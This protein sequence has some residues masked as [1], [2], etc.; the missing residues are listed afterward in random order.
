MA[1][2]SQRVADMSPEKLERRRQQKREYNRRVKENDPERYQKWCDETTK[3]NT[4]EQRKKM[5][6]K[7]RDKR[8]AESRLYRN[9]NRELIL[10]KAKQYAELQKAT[11]KEEFLKKKRESVHKWRSSDKGCEW[12]KNNKHNILEN[13]RARQARKKHATPLWADRKVM[14]KVYAHAR[15]LTEATGIPHEVDH[16]IPLQSD[17]VCG[18]HVEN[19]LQV[20]SR[21]ENRSKSNTVSCI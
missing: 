5:Y 10:T 18:L 7:H 4:P 14:K 3:R 20:I 13:T 9:K 1:R 17:F 15:H 8:I 12:H 16:I 2:K 21:F 19:N 11:N 6:T